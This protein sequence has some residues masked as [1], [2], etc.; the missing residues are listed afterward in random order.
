MQHIEH[1]WLRKSNYRDPIRYVSK[2]YTE[3]DIRDAL[4]FLRTEK[5][6]VFPQ[7]PHRLCR[8]APHPG[9]SFLHYVRMNALLGIMRNNEIDSIQTSEELTQ[10]LVFS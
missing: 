2:T 1:T 9:L 5:T 3:A 4:E 6:V 10:P 7:I 8:K